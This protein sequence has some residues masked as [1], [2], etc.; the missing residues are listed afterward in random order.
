M[1]DKSGSGYRMSNRRFLLFTTGLVCILVIVLFY[2]K[3]Y[4]AYENK[5]VPSVTIEAGTPILPTYFTNEPQY[6]KPAR[7][8]E[9][10]DNKVPGQY[11]L[12]FWCD[13]RNYE[14]VLNIVDTIPPSAEVQDL[15]T[16]VFVLP[17]AS[18]FVT[19]YDD[20]TNVTY[21][22]ETVP[23]VSTGGLKEGTIKFTDTSG[24]ST[25][26]PVKLTVIDDFEAPKLYGVH[27]IEVYEGDNIKYREDLKIED[28]KD[29]NPILEIDN[30]KVDVKKPGTYE[31]TYTV[32]DSTGNSREYTSNVVIMEKPEGYV[33]PE[34][35]YVLAQEVL[36]KITTDD[37]SLE[38]K[39]FA[40]YYWC[41][42]NINYIGHSD[43]SHWT[44]GAYEGFTSLG[45]DCFTYAACAK[46]L[47]DVL[48]VDNY[49]IER[50]DPGTSTH[51]WNYVNIQGGWYF[52]DCS[53][54]NTPL[55]GYLLTEDELDALN[56]VHGPRYHYDHTGL[57]NAATESIQSHINYN[58][59]K[60]DF[61]DEQ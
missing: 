22:Y 10:I 49:I 28:D 18:E 25:V 61:D 42:E 40:V 47:F 53:R 8:L 33:D 24:N 45:G 35:V 60:V 26:L 19:N 38:Q 2:V 54:T 57:P 11:P 9:S 39:G 50:M 6:V 3:Q 5:V 30:S 7:P 15:V 31:V 14:T 55:N 51:F 34:E 29:P 21:A 23:D 16:D 12:T 59:R 56:R 36:D 58:T 52:I 37:M 13:N 20:V 48:G 4:H 46:A 44:K 41:K 32:T 43:K 1:S 27:T 17:E